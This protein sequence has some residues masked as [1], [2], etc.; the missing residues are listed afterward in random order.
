MSDTR[1]LLDRISAFRQRLDATPHLIPDALPVEE[2][3]GA[4]SAEGDAF[5]ESV[6]HIAGAP[7]VVAEGPLPVFTDRAHQLL[8][9]RAQQVRFP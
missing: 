9:K 3:D 1:G 8:A 6:L 4:L 7:T 2:E 5:R